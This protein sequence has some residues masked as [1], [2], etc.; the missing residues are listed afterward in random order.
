MK[1]GS[2]NLLDPSGPVQACNGIAL[3][4]FLLLRNEITL[5]TN[6]RNKTIPDSL[7]CVYVRGIPISWWG[8]PQADFNRLFHTLQTTHPKWKCMW[9]TC[10][11]PK[12]RPLVQY[13]LSSKAWYH[14]KKDII[15]I[16]LQIQTYRCKLHTISLYAGLEHLLWL[17]APVLQATRENI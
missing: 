2:L 17:F 11:Q 10:T 15:T 14:H 13:V 1:S 16:H 9:W 3:P 6:Y 5:R 7:M 8:K 12:T 4:F